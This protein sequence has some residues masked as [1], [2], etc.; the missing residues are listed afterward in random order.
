MSLSKGGG[1]ILL[2]LGDEAASTD[3]VLWIDSGI[4]GVLDSLGTGDSILSGAE[5]R[6]VVGLFSSLFR[7]KN[8][9]IPR[10][11][12]SMKY[13]VRATYCIFLIFA[14]TV[15]L[16]SAEGQ[17]RYSFRFSPGNILT[18]LIS[19]TVYRPRSPSISSEMDLMSW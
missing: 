17:G 11:A 18:L 3:A 4:A 13:R 14:W 19:E 7:Y 9:P 1:A 5:M 2:S 10:Q 6:S 15:S 16:S 8:T 12:P